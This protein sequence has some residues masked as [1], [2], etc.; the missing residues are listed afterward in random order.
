M[1]PDP[2]EF[3]LL[4]LAAFRLFWLLG[5]DTITEP[6]RDWLTKNGRRERTELFLQCPWCAGF[7]ISLGVWGAWLALDEWAVA[8]AVPFAV[9]AVVGT[10]TMALHAISDAE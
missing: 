8:A 6:L 3:A 2:W 9:S 1:I 5:E 4:S 7:W 10:I